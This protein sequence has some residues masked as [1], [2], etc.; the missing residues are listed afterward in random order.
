MPGS[1]SDFWRDLVKKYPFMR[2]PQM[3]QLLLVLGVGLLLLVFSGSWLTPRSDPPASQPAPGVKE[4]PAADDDLTPLEQEL[5]DRLTT[6]LG[7]VDGAGNVQVTLTFQSGITNVY[8][9][10]INKQDQ[11]QSGGGN[12]ATNQVN[13]QDDLALTQSSSGSNT[14]VLVQ[15]LS[16]EIA[17]VLVLADGATNPGVREELVK[18]VETV[19]DIP[20][21]RVMVLPKER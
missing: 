7:S 5:E 18:A 17:G 21:Y 2:G 19:L 9:K 4:Q 8:A 10:N 12:G 11:T 3:W 20:A 14:P 16:P 1:L 13:E 6:I 15:E